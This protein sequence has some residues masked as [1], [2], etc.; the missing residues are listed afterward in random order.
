MSISDIGAILGAITALGVGLVLP[1]LKMWSD[2]NRDKAEQ[3]I[4][5]SRLLIDQLEAMGHQMERGNDR[6][7]ELEKVAEELREALSRE[8]DNR[9]Y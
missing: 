4:G 7:E 6:I 3:E 9:G 2:R 8:R 5:M 1:M